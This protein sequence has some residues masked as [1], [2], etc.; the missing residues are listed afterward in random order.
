MKSKLK[1]IQPA[2]Q[3]VIPDMVQRAARLAAVSCAISTQPYGSGS[4]AK[5][6]G[7][8]AVVSDIKKV[9]GTPGEIFGMIRAINPAQATA[10]WK[11]FQ[12]GNLKRCQGIY[13]ATVS[14][15]MRLNAPWGRFDGG[16]LHKSARQSRG[17]VASHQGKLL[18]VT[19]P[20][21][22]KTYIGKKKKLVGFA[23]GAWAQMARQLGGIRGLRSQA[24]LDDASHDITA[25]WITRHRNAPCR[26][27][28]FD[29][30]S[31]SYVLATSFVD[32]AD[33]TL[34]LS[35]RKQAEYIARMRLKKNI[36]I[37]A[38]YEARKALRRG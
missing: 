17:R 29:N 38:R 10:F 36:M 12:A 37:A 28:R 15:G 14:K 26:I 8:T 33:D 32:Y 27:Q 7:E 25:S 35:E 16:A 21:A 19:N 24:S 9:Y 6:A 22:L 4:D 13:E 34:P 2:L 11:Y 3:R 30:G 1:G 31:K 5:N 20:S 18:I 23:K